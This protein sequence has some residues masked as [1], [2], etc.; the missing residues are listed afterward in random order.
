V[1]FILK[2]SSSVREEEEVAGN[3]NISG[4]QN[5]APQGSILSRLRSQRRPGS[6]FARRNQQHTEQ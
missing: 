6:I 3:V 1:Y 4:G 5:A 2:V